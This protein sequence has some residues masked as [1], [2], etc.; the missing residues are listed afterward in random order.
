LW[1][2]YTTIC[3]YNMYY[4]NQLVMIIQN[5]FDKI[6]FFIFYVPGFLYPGIVPF[7]VL[8]TP[9]PTVALSLHDLIPYFFPRSTLRYKKQHLLKVFFGACPTLRLKHE[10]IEKM[11]ILTDLFLLVSFVMKKILRCLICLIFHENEI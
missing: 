11:V 7:L 8:V 3:R 4:H 2:N 9:H 10:K 6:Y 1:C 5:F